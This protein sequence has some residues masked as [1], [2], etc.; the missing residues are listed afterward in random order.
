MQSLLPCPSGKQWQV[1]TFDLNL[2]GKH[3]QKAVDL[4]MAP[5]GP[6]I[7]KYLYVSLEILFVKGKKSFT[8]FPFR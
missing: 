4:P 6:T 1:G 5:G 8:S 2:G 7:L 3:G